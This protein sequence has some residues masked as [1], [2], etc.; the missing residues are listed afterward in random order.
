M[1]RAFHVS[2]IGAASRWLRNKPAGSITTWEGGQYRAAGLG[3]YQRNNG[4]S[5]YPTRRDSMEE[6]LS[7]FMIESAKRHEENSNIIKEI[8]ASSDAT[9]RSQGASIKTLEL[10]IGQMSKVLQERGFRS[11]HSS[12]ENNPKDQV[13][14]ISTATTDLHEIRHM[15]HG[16]YAVSR[17]HHIFVFP[18][19]TSF[20]RRLHNYCCYDLVEAH[21]VNILDTYNNNLPL[22]EN[23]LRSFTLSFLINNTCFNKAFVDLEASV[24]VMPL[25]T[26]TTLSLGNLTHTRMTIELADRTIKQPKG[27]ASN[28]LV[29]IGKFV[30]LVDFVILD[31]PEDDDVP[32]ILGRPFLSIAHVKI[33]VYKRK[34][35]AEMKFDLKKNVL[36]I[37]QSV[38][39]SRVLAALFDDD[40]W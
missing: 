21:G 1:L 6:S 40:L 7:I 2:L 39:L 11:L 15:D 9:I 23:D 36:K 32:L 24:S 3:F 16:S 13:K 31:V 8:R 12:T 18:K 35:L 5:S 29:G 38:E 30:F 22:K 19:T 17:P 25:S 14:L 34:D 33:D 27:I 20:P 4:N 28:V 10:Q 26:Y 37:D